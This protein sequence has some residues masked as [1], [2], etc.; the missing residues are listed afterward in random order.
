MPGK[1]LFVNACIRRDRSRTLRLARALIGRYPDHVVDEIVLEDM[2]L[3]PLD[4]EFLDRRDALIGKGDYSDPIFDIA[5]RFAGADVIVVASP[6]W[7]NCFASHLKIFMEHAAALGIAFRY[8]PDGS[9]T[10]MCRARVLYYV[11]TRGGPI[12][13]EADLGYSVYRSLC[14]IYGIKGCRIVSA[15]AL[16]IVTNDAGRIMEDAVSRIGEMDIL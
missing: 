3:Q 15:S 13:D 10:G 16:D 5:K 2:R 9:I 7:E 1:L 12:P 11:T 4:S 6:Y 8:E 14:D